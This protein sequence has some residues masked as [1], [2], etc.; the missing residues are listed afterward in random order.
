MNKSLERIEQQIHR[1]AEMMYH[2]G[3]DDG[4]EAE[5][6]HR[7]LCEEEQEPILDKIRAEI[8]AI[9]TVKITL[10][11]YTNIIKSPQRIKD[12]VLE[13]I[14]KYKAEMEVEE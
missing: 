1:F 14:D 13:I 6:A 7:D 9:D 5:A 10:C 2:M 8:E 11:D 12:E 4:M 3:Y